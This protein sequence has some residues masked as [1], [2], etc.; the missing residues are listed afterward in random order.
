[1]L[2]LLVAVVEVDPGMVVVVEPARLSMPPLSTYLL[3]H[4]SRFK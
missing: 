1:M 3:L 2:R 4:P